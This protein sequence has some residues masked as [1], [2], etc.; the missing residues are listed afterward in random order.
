LRRKAD[1]QEQTYQKK[2]QELGEKKSVFFLEI[3]HIMAKNIPCQLQDL[4]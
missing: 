3:S 1:E 2:L 4:T